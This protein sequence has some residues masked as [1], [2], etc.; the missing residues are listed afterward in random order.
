MYIELK[1]EFEVRTPFNGALDN[2]RR[3]L[4]GKFKFKVDPE[5]TDVFQK[6]VDTFTAD[7]CAR[8]TYSRLDGLAITIGLIQNIDMYTLF[9]GISSLNSSHGIDELKK[10]SNELLEEAYSQIIPK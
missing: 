8:F 7:D 5:N 6:Y 3:Y 2:L 4:E 10:K 9:V 1:K